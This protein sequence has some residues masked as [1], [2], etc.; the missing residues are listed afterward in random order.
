M[1]TS[2]MITESGFVPYLHIPA[3]F[4]AVD[5]FVS[6]GYVPVQSIAPALLS[7]L[8]GIDIVAAEQA[9]TTIIAALL[10]LLTYRCT[11]RIT[12]S[13]LAGITAAALL[14]ST[15]YVFARLNFFVPENVA[16]CFFLAAFLSILSENHRPFL[17]AVLLLGG[18]AFHPRSFIFYGP[19]L[20][21]FWFLQRTPRTTITDLTKI[22]IQKESLG[23]AAAL[24]G[25]GLP[26]LEALRINLYYFLFVGA[27]YTLAVSFEGQA[28]TL[29]QIDALL[30]LYVIALAVPAVAVLVSRW[31]T[32]NP[33]MKGLLMW[34]TVTWLMF[35]GA[36][37]RSFPV[38]RF[39]FY[40]AVPT[41]ILG[42]FFVQLLV[43][44]LPRGQAVRRRVLTTLVVIAI[45][46][47]AAYGLWQSPLR[48]P[49]VVWGPDERDAMGYL[50][51]A[52]VV[53]PSFIVFTPE[54]SLPYAYGI[55]HVEF[56]EE[57]IAGILRN[58][59]TVEDVRCRLSDTYPGASTFFIVL[60]TVS[61]NE[62]GLLFPVLMLF[63]PANATF[64]RPTVWI[65]S[66]DRC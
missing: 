61:R 20:L 1:G 30:N 3:P 6:I 47:P 9:Q 17:V 23:A 40:V 43:S 26:F 64:A 11:R 60:T 46:A 13:Y 66:L 58:A 59:T 39:A 42:G 7:I 4:A 27:T 44:R 5:T 31:R 19:I 65:Y 57:V 21:V 62:L 36:P 56:R 45:V 2:R 54:Y 37:L 24:L 10:M 8:L 15:P 63:E 41:A 28:P 12:G 49:W 52:T 34:W 35:F 38:D 33:G 48:K 55:L 25:T 32:I 50:E 22:L 51:Q 53:S 18:M 14:L 16:L 29:G